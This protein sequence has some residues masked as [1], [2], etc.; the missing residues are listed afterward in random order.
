MRHL[1]S[2]AVV[3]LAM[4]FGSALA[5][6][7]ITSSHTNLATKETGSVSGFIE[8]DRLK[9]VTPQATVIF[10]GDLNKTWVIGT[11]GNTYV[12]ITPEVVSAF[13][14]R[15]AAAQLPGSADQAKLQER[16]AKLP[17]AQRALAEQ[18]LRALGGGAAAA[19]Q[20]AYSKAGQTKSMPPGRCEVYVK[21]VS[22]QKQE[23]LCIAPLSVVG[24][25]PADFRV[26]D[27]FAAFMGPIANSPVAPRADY[28]NW[29]EMSKAIGFSGIP[30][31]TT[32]LSA[33]K[34][35]MRDAVQKIERVSVSADAFELPTGLTKRELTGAR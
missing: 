33:G 28:L 11:P 7:V 13:A 14:A 5:G 16:L 22:G 20:V 24:L 23:D 19:Q 10:R 29:G 26:L 35:A 27:L 32:L 15:I 30:L 17:P 34:P 18:Q 1:M 25:S 6:V 9:I 3:V 2:L 4:G 31:E 8:A 21:T 12:E